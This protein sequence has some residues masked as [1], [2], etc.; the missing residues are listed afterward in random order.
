MAELARR[1]RTSGSA[2]SRAEKGFSLGFFDEQYLSRFPIAVIETRRPGSGVREYLDGG[3][4]G[5]A[6][7]RPHALRTEGAEGRDGEP[8]RAPDGVGQGEGYRHGFRSAWRRCRASNDRRS[9]RCG[10]GSDRF[11]TS[12]AKG[13]ITFR[14]SDCSRTSSIR[15]GS[16]TTWRIPAGSA[17]PRVLADVTAL[18]AGGYRRR[19]SG[20]GRTRIERPSEAGEHVEAEGGSGVAVDLLVFNLHGRGADLGQRAQHP[21]AIVEEVDWPGA[22]ASGRGREG[23][24]RRWRAWPWPPSARGQAAGVVEVGERTRR[25]R[26]PGPRPTL[27]AG[28]SD[29]RL[30]RR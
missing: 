1:S 29:E 17:L 15:S 10:P 27:H 2:T 24:G 18:I 6:V 9:R 3:G 5:R 26:R 19:L 23:R 14:A 13:S 22:V 25:R 16:R 21:A 28:S 20:G 4:H 30:R 12:T 8:V 7:D 11:S